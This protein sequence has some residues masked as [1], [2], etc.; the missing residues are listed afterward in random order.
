LYKIL[1]ALFIV[2]RRERG[3]S[4]VKEIITKWDKNKGKLEQWFKTAHPE[5]YKAIV[6]KLFELVINDSDDSW[7]NFD[8]SKMT[9]ID[10]GHYQGT[11]IFIVPK[12]TYQPSVGDYLVT[13]TYYGSCSGCDTLEGIRSYEDSAPSEGQ[14]KDY[15]T[16]AL[17]LVQKLRWLSA[18]ENE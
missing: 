13:D 8:V 16:L 12:G 5:S 1:A 17:H 11:Q 15:M 10:N 4:V 9:M 14:V 2:A 6:E 7:E 18:G 3:V